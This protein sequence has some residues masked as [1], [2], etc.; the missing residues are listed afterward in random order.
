MSEEARKRGSE[1]SAGA[2][3]ERVV[4]EFVELFAT[5]DLPPIK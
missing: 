5:A 4:H 1:R 2:E 3:A